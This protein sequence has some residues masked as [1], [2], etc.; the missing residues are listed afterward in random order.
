M[1][2]A[3]KK[4]KQQL[5]LLPTPFSS[6]VI[7][8]YLHH[9][10]CACYLFPPLFFLSPYFLLDFSLR[11]KRAWGSPKT[12]KIQLFEF[13]I[14]FLSIYSSSYLPTEYLNYLPVSDAAVLSAYTPQFS[15]PPF[16]SPMPSQPSFVPSELVSGES[17]DSLSVHESSESGCPAGGRCVNQSCNLYV[18]SLPPD[19][20]DADLFA[21]FA[22]F[23]PIVSA[24]AMCKKG[25]KECK[26]YGFVLFQREEDALRAQSG[27]IGHMIG[28]NKIQVRR[29]RAT[30]CTPLME[31][32]GSKERGAHLRSETSKNTVP[33]MNVP[34]M[35]QQA[36]A[37]A[38]PVYFQPMPYP[39]AAAAPA[40]Q[41][42]GVPLYSPE[43]STNPGFYYFYYYYYYLFIYLFIY[44]FFCNQIRSHFLFA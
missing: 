8:P 2:T 24:K 36:V 35:A 5:P 7:Y 44:Y 42:L 23:G 18:A 40:M 33:M 25:L 31:R 21:L 17:Y 27:M 14:L 34:G 9:K 19:C 16:M 41:S 32:S 11:L 20:T 37:A 30:A 38:P 3:K 10:T 13:S 28:N 43:A 26:G 22:P 6:I 29:A 39:A 4:K 1:F 15:S 12:L